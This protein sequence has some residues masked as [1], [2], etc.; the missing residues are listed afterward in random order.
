MCMF[1]NTQ[2]YPISK[3]APTTEGRDTG[4]SIDPGQDKTLLRASVAVP[5]H[6]QMHRCID[7]VGKRQ[8]QTRYLRFYPSVTATFASIDLQQC[9]APHNGCRVRPARAMGSRYM[10][11]IENDQHSISRRLRHDTIRLRKKRKQVLLYLHLSR[12]PK[13]GKWL[14]HIM[15]NHMARKARISWRREKKGK[16]HESSQPLGGRD[17]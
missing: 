9:C 10:G 16:F 3:H 11:L 15:T 2:Q 8:R 13:C 6:R 5:G 1:R 7:K 4:T 12:A 17:Q 14:R